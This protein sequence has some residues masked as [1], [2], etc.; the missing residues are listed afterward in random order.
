[1]PSYQELILKTQRTLSLNLAEGFVLQVTE[2]LHHDPAIEREAR[3]GIEKVV[4]DF[5]AAIDAV[6]PGDEIS[7]AKLALS[8]M[9]SQLQGDP[10]RLVCAA[11]NSRVVKW[12]LTGEGKGAVPLDADKLYATAVPTSLLQ[13]ILDALNA[14]PIVPKAKD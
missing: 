5:E 4:A 9:K 13:A 3:A 10:R 11:I 1:M 8:S 14:E 12:D 6:K 2:N 7:S